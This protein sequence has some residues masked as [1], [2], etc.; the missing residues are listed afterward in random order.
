MSS[1]W[2]AQST[3]SCS[4]TGPSYMS[5][6][7]KSWLHLKCK[8]ATSTEF[9]QRW[10]NPSLPSEAGLLATHRMAAAYE[11]Y[12]YKN[13]LDAALLEGRFDAFQHHVVRIDVAR[14]TVATCAYYSVDDVFV[15][16]EM[17]VLHLN[18]LPVSE[19]QTVAVFSYVPRL[20]RMARRHLRPMLRKD[21]SH[22]QHDL[23]R[24]LI[25][26]C[27]NLVLPSD[28]VDSWDMAKREAIVRD[29]MST[30]LRPLETYDSS[31]FDLFVSPA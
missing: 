18:V 10:D 30:A 16:D 31:Y 27:G 24:L 19:T 11:T 13:E 22:R 23:S 21:G 25:E 1:T 6:T 3:Y 17:L 28:Y 9:G 2:I 7:R 29:F 4:R 8:A 26:H 20:G 5:C 12:L 15:K 14:P